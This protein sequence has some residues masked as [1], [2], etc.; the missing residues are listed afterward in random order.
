[1]GEVAGTL[2]V[3][4][5]RRESLLGVRNDSS[6][7]NAQASSVIESARRFIFGSDPPLLDPSILE[8]LNESQQLAVLAAASTKFQ[9][10]F[11]SRNTST[12]ALRDAGRQPQWL[13]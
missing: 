8:P 13:G 5:M 6:Q 4:A 2:S 11:S 3:C 1:M 7:T 9:N 12:Q 10:V